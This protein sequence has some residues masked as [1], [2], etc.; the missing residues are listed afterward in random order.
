ML[1]QDGVRC[2]G[3]N[4]ILEVYKDLIEIPDIS[5]RVFLD[6]NFTTPALMNAMATS[7]G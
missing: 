6:L 1:R 3:S 2:S 4:E 7:L 5:V